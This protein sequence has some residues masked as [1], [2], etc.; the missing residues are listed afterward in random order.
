M[1]D[2]PTVLIVE[3]EIPIR[4]FL[5]AGLAGSYRVVEAASGREGLQMV[6]TH[7]PDIILLDLG[8][9]D[10]DGVEVV[11]ELREWSQVP[12]LIL[13]ARGLEADKVQALDTGANDYITKPFGMPELLARVRACLRTRP[14]AAVADS[15]VVETPTLKIDT[16]K[17]EVFRNGELV[18]L[19]PTEYRLLSVLVHN[20]GKVLTHRQ[21]LEQVWG[22]A[23]IRQTQYLRVYM[24]QLR[25]KLEDDP[26]RPQHLITE[27]SVGYRFRL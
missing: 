16:N 19:T 26:G 8:L 1:T 18:H 27:S 6:T 21:L 7:N 9:P 11:N 12:V 2:L 24:G 15:P 20:A 5:R 13:S 25:H 23:Y 22:A 17:R 10:M 3:D 14:Q 4:R